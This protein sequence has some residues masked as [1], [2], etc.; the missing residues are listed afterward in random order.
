MDFS[1]IM[2]LGEP[3]ITRDSWMDEGARVTLSAIRA[4]LS[5]L[6][7]GELHF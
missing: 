4:T 5:L 3:L 1:A 6:Y 7:D 2:G